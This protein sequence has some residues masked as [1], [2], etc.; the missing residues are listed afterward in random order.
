MEIAKEEI[1][2]QKFANDVIKML[3]PPGKLDCLMLSTPTRKTIKSRT[4]LVFF[5]SLFTIV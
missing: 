5:I 1:E 2:T 4:T 3:G